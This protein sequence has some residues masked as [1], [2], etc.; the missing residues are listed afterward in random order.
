M[1]WQEVRDIY[2]DQYVLLS[3]LN[4]HLTEDKKIID[5]VA[6]IRP[7]DNAKEATD[8]LMHAEKNTIVYHTKNEE[9]VIEVRKPSIRWGV[10]R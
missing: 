3:I 7:L 8:E 5:D 2:P 6:L 4:S 10:L 1:K 9:I